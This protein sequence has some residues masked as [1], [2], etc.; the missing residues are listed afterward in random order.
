LL[1][2]HPDTL[3]L[4]TLVPLLFVVG[5]IAGLPLSLALPWFRTAYL[6]GLALYAAVVA[7]GS[8]WA[9]CSPANRALLLRLPLVFATIHFSSGLG[10]LLELCGLHGRRPRTEDLHVDHPR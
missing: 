6:A 8:L 9:G 1:R 7:L 10:M 3:A 5:L 4:G 2:K